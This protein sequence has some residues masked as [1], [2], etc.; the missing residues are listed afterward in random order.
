MLLDFQFNKA[1]IADFGN[2]RMIELDSGCGSMTN[3]P[4]TLDYM[5]PEAMGGATIHY[6]SLDV[7]SL[8]HLSLFTMISQM[9][10]KPRL[11]PSYA[12]SKDRQCYV[13]H[14]VE[15]RAQFL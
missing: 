1:K 14:E 7:F 6:P 5:P 11:P 12:D 15:R 3:A 2:S 9:P 8:G 10:L 4:G 13:C